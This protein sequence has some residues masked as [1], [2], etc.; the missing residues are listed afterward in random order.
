[1][2]SV[3]HT[4]SP[5]STTVILGRS[6]VV[7]ARHWAKA[8]STRAGQIA[9][10]SL[11]RAYIGEEVPANTTVASVTS[12]SFLAFVAGSMKLNRFLNCSLPVPV[13]RDRCA[14]A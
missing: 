11:E 3:A 7:L 13:A 1:M 4:Q 2:A 10:G 6:W 9:P 5:Y 12:N 8:F 14:N